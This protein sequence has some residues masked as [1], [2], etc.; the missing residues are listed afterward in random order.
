MG[1]IKKLT[2][3]NLQLKRKRTIVTI[4][5]IILSGAMIMGVGS[6][7]ASFQDFFLRSAIQSD[8][9]YHASLY[10]V[11]VDKV[12]TIAQDQ[13]VAAVMLSRLKVL[14]PLQPALKDI[15]LI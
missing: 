3:R 14:S 12:E 8:G 11:A 2:L 1:I 10:D 5:G 13:A 6:I 4:I 15:N 9:N 7:A